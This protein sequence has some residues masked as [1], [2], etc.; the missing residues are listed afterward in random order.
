MLFLPKKPPLHLSFWNQD[1]GRSNCIMRAEYLFGIQWLHFRWWMI[2]NVQILSSSYKTEPL[3]MKRTDMIDKYNGV[4]SENVLPTLPCLMLLLFAVGDFGKIRKIF[5]HQS[6]FFPASI[7][8]H[9]SANPQLET[10]RNQTQIWHRCRT[11]AP[12]VVVVE[13]LQWFFLGSPALQYLQY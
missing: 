9:A 5:K 11:G 6:N 4:S 1:R 2:W 8:S 10:F 13:S 3:K 7:F 12:T